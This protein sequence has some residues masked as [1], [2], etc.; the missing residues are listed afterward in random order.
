[1]PDGAY[2]KGVNP[3]EAEVI[4]DEIAVLLQSS[5]G[6]PSIGVVTFNV[7][8]RQVILDTVDQRCERDPAFSEAWA[9]ASTHEILDQRPFVKNLE[10]VQGDERDVILFS[11]GH[12]PVPRRSGPLKG[13][14]YVPSRFGP[15][16]QAGGER[17][18]N[19]AVSR[20]KQACVVVCSFEPQM[21]SVVHTKNEGPKL[22][23]AFLEF[24]WDLTHGRRV[25]ADKTLQ[26]VRHGGLGAVAKARVERLGVPSLAAQIAMALETEAVQVD[27]NVGNS[28][29]QVPL[30]LRKG[31]HYT[32]AVLTEEGH[33]S[34]DVN[35]RHVHQPGVLRARGWAVE[36]VNAR[37]WHRDAGAVLERL[38]GRH[39]EVLSLR[40][41]APPAP[42]PALPEPPASGP[43]ADLPASSPE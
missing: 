7:Q 31:H 29:F 23:K 30:A 9:I 8:Q 26:R 22:L 5:G 27:L 12:A 14:L 17:R 41:A 6:V 15:L 20:A 13:Q 28:G 10:S 18:L 16:G 25:Q 2:D 43:P 4:V 1:M 35:E 37:D 33:G 32:L 38:L 36:R 3:R 24:A 21:L 34:G 42:T 19:V 11:M 40:E 39:R